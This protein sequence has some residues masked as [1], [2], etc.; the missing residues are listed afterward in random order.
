MA[1]SIVGSDQCTGNIRERMEDNCAPQKEPLVGS[2][3]KGW[4]GAGGL[5][6]M[7]SDFG[8]LQEG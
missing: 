7:E 6:L 5:K 1:V 8:H 2:A 4:R 3:T